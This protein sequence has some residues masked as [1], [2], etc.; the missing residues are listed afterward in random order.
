LA[1]R[2]GFVGVFGFFR[3]SRPFGVTPSSANGL[4]PC[5]TWNPAGENA[6]TLA[7][8]REIC[9]RIEQFFDPA[10]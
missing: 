10:Q 7:N 4:N 9:A 5:A 1:R 2:D 3:D 6:A 8:L